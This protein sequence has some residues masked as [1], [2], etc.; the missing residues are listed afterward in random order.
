MEGLN[1]RINISFKFDGR[2]RAYFISCLSDHD[3]VLTFSF[4]VL[5]VFD[6]LSEAFMALA[7]DFM[8]RFGDYEQEVI[9]DV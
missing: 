6:T 7:A 4:N 2:R 1:G 3:Y 8:I 9:S 5:G